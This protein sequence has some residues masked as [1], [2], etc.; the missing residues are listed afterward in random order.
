MC[1]FKGGCAYLHE[2]KENK[3]EKLNQQLKDLAM[4]HE[5]GL[6]SLTKAV[7]MFKDLVQNLTLEMVKAIMKK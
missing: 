5:K 7:D 4:K 2:K 3:Q 1:R 6:T